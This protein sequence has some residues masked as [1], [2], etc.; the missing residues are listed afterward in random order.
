MADIDIS[1]SKE[2]LFT[3]T[4]DQWEWESLTVNGQPQPA[5]NK[6]KIQF[7]YC[8]KESG[9]IHFTATANKWLGV[10]H[11]GVP[12]FMHNSDSKKTYLC[13]LSYTEK[14]S[15]K[16]TTLY[17]HLSTIDTLIPGSKPSPMAFTQVRMTG[18]FHTVK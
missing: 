15:P 8:Q 5:I 10:I 13:V 6:D 14:E 11:H 7:Q 12:L 1:V 9:T 2:D 16:K 3:I 17:V 18:R 4:L